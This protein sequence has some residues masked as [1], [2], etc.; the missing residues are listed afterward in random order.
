[1]SFDRLVFIDSLTKA[2]VDEPVARAHADALRQAL[3]ETVAT[4]A[5]LADVA[6]TLDRKIDMLDRKI[7]IT[8]RDLTIKGA[9][10]LIVIASLMIGLKLFG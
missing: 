8:A 7:E 4:K 6:Q 9:A 10:G 1:M 3:M 2:G 5:D